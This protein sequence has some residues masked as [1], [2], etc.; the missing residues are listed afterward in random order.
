MEGLENNRHLLVAGK[1]IRNLPVAISCYPG[2]YHNKDECAHV[3]SHRFNSTFQE[4]SPVGYCYPTDDACPPVDLRKDTPG[5]C[6]LGPAPVYTINATEPAEL[7]AGM[8]FAQRHNV[9]LVVRNTG[10]DILGKSE[11]YGALQ[12]W[13][14][15]IQKGIT[16]QEKYR[17]SDKCSNSDWTGAALTIG[18]G[19]VWADVYEF[20]FKRGITVVGGG[21]PTVGC[22][23]GYTQGGGHSPASHEYGLAADQVLETQVVLANGSIVTAN[24]CQHEDLFFALRGGGGGSYGVVISMTVKGYPTK[25]VVAQSLTIMPLTNNTEVLLD[26][27]TQV[28][29]DYPRL[30]DA[31]FSGYGTWSINSP[32]V[33]FA[34]QEVGYVHAIAAMD[35]SLNNA[36]NTFQPL[37]QKLEKY[38]GTSLRISVTWFQFPTYAAYY[39]AMSGVHQTVG[40]SRSALTSR[41]FSKAAL[42]DSPPDLRKMIGV[43]AGQP[44]E[45]TINSVELVGGGK[46]IANKDDQYSGVNPAWRS[47]YVVNVVARGWADGSDMRTV[48]NVRDD[49]T[50]D[51][52]GA[53]R[54]QTPDGG[55]Y[56]NEADKNDPQWAFDF[57]GSHYPRLA[58][59]KKKYDP[60]DLF[61]CHTCVGS[62]SWHQQYLD[63]KDYGPLCRNE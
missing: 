20:V 12:I 27:I 14:K 1:L 51:K 55:S 29:E 32:T 58:A 7:A 48:Q 52:G 28:W 36:K 25:P 60:N 40:S 41:M 5:T 4:H 24:P 39:R 10:H 2:P 9:R 53:M 38:N 13:I 19:Y 35:K 8:A 59:I 11:G 44:E 23:G 3:Y 45:H 17:P 54:L 31:G 6:T 47:T 63:G 30:M 15:Y 33:L 37:L 26:A 21:D 50:Y 57:Y 22:I 62:T 49:I 42:T 46:V 18:G 56:M 61:W 43:I 16:I 34:K